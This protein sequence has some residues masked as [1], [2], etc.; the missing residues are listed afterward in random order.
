MNTIDLLNLKNWFSGYCKRFYPAAR[1][2][3]KNIA[4]KEFHTR[5]V[6]ANMVLIAGA[7]L[8]NRNKVLMAEAIGL[9]HDIGRFPQYAQYRTFRDNISVNHGRLGAEVLETEKPLSGLPLSEQELIIDAVRFHNA[10]SIP[11]ELDPEKVFF[12]KM[13]RDADKLD[14]WRFFSEYYEKDEVERESA[15]GLDLPDTPEYSEEVLACLF[16]KKSAAYS[17]LKTL[18]DFKLMQ[19]TWVY[20]LNFPASFSLASNQGC[21]D[22]VISSLPERKEISQAVSALRQYI[23]NMASK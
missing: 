15:A 16:G 22:K 12:L 20:D 17:D 4:L 3:R 19:L 5:K 2:D 8:Q 6:A 23:G 21:I 13:I 7:E 11:G 18:N 1:E 10:F 9:L 14:I